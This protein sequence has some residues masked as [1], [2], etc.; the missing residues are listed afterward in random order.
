MSIPDPQSLKWPADRAL[1]LVHGV[2]NAKPGDY[3][4]LVK[5][6]TGIL[7]GLPKPYAVY[8][9]YYDYINEWF[10]QRFQAPLA[11]T[12][13]MN[14]LHARVGGPGLG[15]TIASFVGD[16]IWPILS[17]DGRDA[18]RTALFRQIRQILLDGA[19]A[20]IPT[21]ERR[22][23]IICH[24]LGC[25]HV[26]EALH[27]AASDTTQ[28]LSPA[29]GVQFDNVIFMASPVQL[30]AT[31]GADIRAAV[32]R[33]SD[34]ACMSSSSLQM[35]SADDGFGT[36]VPTARR[37]ASITG[38][39]DPVGGYVSRDPLAWAYMNLPG[40]VSE[41]DQQELVGM[42]SADLQT[43]LQGALHASAPPTITPQNP[44]DWSNYVARHASDLQTWL[45]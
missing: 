16:V 18:V 35:P 2:G 19:T 7:A 32:P 4:P 5:Q 30:I 14:A 44:H 40:Q 33:A 21:P 25:F 23:S 22:L 20:G 39:L 38:N 12:Q 26:F 10:S 28:Q 31:I 17:L 42:K 24:S 8:M 29:Q 41:I 9:F 36:R 13:L 43:I 11:V 34:L 6:V 15:D 37:T 1:L 27:A 45:A 3:D